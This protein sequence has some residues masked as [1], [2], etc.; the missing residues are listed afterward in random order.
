VLQAPSSHLGVL[1]GRGSDELG[2]SFIPGGIWFRDIE[3]GDTRGNLSRFMS[4]FQGNVAKAINKHLGRRGDFWAREFDD[5]LV[6]E[7]CGDDFLNRYVYII[8]NSVKAGLTEKAEEWIGLNSLHAALTGEVLSFTGVNRTTKHLLTRRKRNIDPSRYTETYE[9]ELTPPP[10]LAHLSHSERAREILALTQNGEAEFKEKRCNLP[11]LGIKSIRKQKWSD[12][13]R[14]SSF[15]PRIKIFASD[16]SRKQELLEG[17]RD[18]VGLY[19]ENYGVY[20][21][22]IERRRR[23]VIAWP[24]WSFPPSTSIPV[25]PQTL[26]AAG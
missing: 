22:A 10:M 25:Y 26:L 7:T 11:A 1:V 6:D 18:F 5:V 21:K 14:N 3:F 19:R 8:C 2:H 20:L 24:E 12:R 13:P 23:P 15:R 17:Y 16:P 4:Y 9:L